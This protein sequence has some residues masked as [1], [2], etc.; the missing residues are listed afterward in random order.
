MSDT[1]KNLFGGEALSYEELVRRAGEAKVA[2]GDL[3]EAE[4]RH[5]REL[6]GVR[7][8]FALERSLE[9]AGAKN[10]GLVKRSVDMSSVTVEDGVVKGID[11]Q[12]SALRSSDPYLFRDR[13]STSTGSPHGSS[14][15]NP[16]SLSDADFYRMR[17]GGN[18]GGCF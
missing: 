11:E 3:A 1:I 9:K 6:D 7:I 4:A 8:D 10:V 13:D 5:K 16:D 2:I 18:D 12:L 14:P 17:M 15:Q